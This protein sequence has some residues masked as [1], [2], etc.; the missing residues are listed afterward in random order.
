M[1]TA[2]NIAVVVI[3]AAANIYLLKK[4]IN[5]GLLMVLDSAI[6]AI[7]AR[8]PVLTALKSGISGVISESTIS[9]I[10]LLFLILTLENIMRTS[11]MIKTM[12]ASL[13]EMVGSRRAAVALM[14]AVIGLLPS[15][16]GARLS[17]PMVE[18]VLGDNSVGPD[19]AFVNY[20]FR[21]IW[22][23]G[24]ILYPGAILASKL[25]GISVISFFLHVLP[26]MVFQVI[27]GIIFG[28]RLIKKENIEKT[29]PF[30]ENFKT[31]AISILPIILV[32]TLY[33]LLLDYFTYSLEL[34]VI[35]MV[36]ALFIIKKYDFKRI[37]TTLREAFP[38]KLVAIIAGAMVFK[39]V[40]LD[41]KV[42]DGLPDIMSSVGIPV[43]ILFL[44]LPFVGGFASGIT[45]SYLS[46]TFP[47]LLPLGLDKNIW[48]TVLAFCAGYVGVMVTPLHL[49]AVMSAD[50]F[51]ASLTGLLGRVAAAGALML[52][53][54][55]VILFVMVR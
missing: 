9:L 23:D 38:V 24:F 29:R 48:Y 21:H 54:T 44:L 34:S 47:F 16:G 20:W 15:P 14:P 46:L 32:I 35:L 50:Y 17:C 25:V 11:G 28:T 6:V 13:K 1:T 31:F 8:I 12:V 26:F 36:I 43:S 33:I 52:V 7:L 27:L 41:S 37:K 5:L 55:S 42:L 49:C 3:A 51:K 19:K 10:I 30:S 39:Q 18:E 22:M 40:L 53:V 4:E 45:V 2:I